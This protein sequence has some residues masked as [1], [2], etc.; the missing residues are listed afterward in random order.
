MVTDIKEV[1][2]AYTSLI[3]KDLKTSSKFGDTYFKDD[4]I[5]HKFGTNKNY[6][7]VELEDIPNGL[8]C[9][10]LD[11]IIKVGIRIDSNF[12]KKAIEKIIK[13]IIFCI[14][15]KNRSGSNS[16]TMAKSCVLNF[17]H[18]D[19][20]IHFL[21]LILIDLAHDVGPY[22]IGKKLGLNTEK[23]GQKCMI[24]K[25]KPIEMF[26]MYIK[27]LE[28]LD[29]SVKTII[30]D[31]IIE[32][33]NYQNDKVSEHKFILQK[34][35]MIKSISEVDDK[36]LGINPIT[37]NMI[38]HIFGRIIGSGKYELHST[39]SSSLSGGEAI[40]KDFTRSYLNSRRLQARDEID[41]LLKKS[42]KDNSYDTDSKFKKIEELIGNY[43]TKKFSFGTRVAK[44][45]SAIMDALKSTPVVFDQSS[46]GT[47]HRFVQP[48]VH[49]FAE[50]VAI[51][52]D[53]GLSQG[54]NP[55]T[56][57]FD[58]IAYLF[59]SKKHLKKTK[60]QVIPCIKYH[61]EMKLKECE[62][63]L[64]ECYFNILIRLTNKVTNP[65]E[66][67]LPNNIYNTLDTKYKINKISHGNLKYYMTENIYSQIHMK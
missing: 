29:N 57:M 13:Q 22:N 58:Y 55:T 59:K 31:R 49:I 20:V 56:T 26:Y 28:W 24:Y 66:N 37:L 53:K 11:K 23:V 36:I 51:Y 41:K 17:S 46:K 44:G 12:L 40:A 38:N 45:D 63:K 6:P 2:D 62:I 39:S 1:V 7:I 4:W 64:I 25:N 3:M 32:E 5:K 16:H 14:I 18:I 35:V 21:A 67:T 27:S 48:L 9:P 43:L 42:Y 61:R 8:N 54:D 30:L 33:C 10:E 47:I 15:N 50:S 65:L 52:A 19:D 60:D 34:G